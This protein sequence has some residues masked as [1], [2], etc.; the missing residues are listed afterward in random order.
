MAQ[1]AVAQKVHMHFGSLYETFVSLFCAISGGTKK[2]KIHVEA[3]LARDSK[4]VF[5]W[6]GFPFYVWVWLVVCWSSARRLPVVGSGSAGGQ[7]VVCWWSACGLL[8]VHLWTAGR[9]LVVPSRGLL[10]V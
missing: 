3:S 2:P 1:I 9:L 8:V 5:F 6:Y 4:N 7:L 10:V